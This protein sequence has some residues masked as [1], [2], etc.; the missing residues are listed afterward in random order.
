MQIGGGLVGALVGLLMSDQVLA[1]A[2]VIPGMGVLAVAAH[3]GLGKV[4]RI[5]A[6][7]G[8]GGGGG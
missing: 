4:N 2:T 5:R 1:L 6:A 7:G 3:A 8:A